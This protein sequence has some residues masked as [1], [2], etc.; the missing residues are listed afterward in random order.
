MLEQLSTRRHPVKGVVLDTHALIW[1]LNAPDRLSAKATASMGN[2]L[3]SG[4]FLHFSVISMV[5][6]IYLVEKG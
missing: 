4:G 3:Q 6:I 5:E 1:Y 2:S